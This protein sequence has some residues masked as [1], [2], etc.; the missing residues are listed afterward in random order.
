MSGHRQRAILSIIS[1]Y[2]N[3]TILS[4][5]VAR[6]TCTPRNTHPPDDRLSLHFRPLAASPDVES[7]AQPTT[8]PAAG[9]QTPTNGSRGNLLQIIQHGYP[10]SSNLS[11]KV[12]IIG[13]LPTSSH[14]SHLNGVT[15]SYTSSFPARPRPLP[16]L[17]APS[18]RRTF[19]VPSSSTGRCISS[20]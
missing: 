8:Q 16:F 4:N 11:Q 15:R 12:S 20:R 10:H 5:V 19:P 13:L 18:S 17:N 2:S 14:S 1:K 6:R 9:Q 7:L 3:P